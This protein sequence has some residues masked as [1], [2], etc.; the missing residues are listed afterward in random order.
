VTN[1]PTF[2]YH[3]DPLAT[4]SIAPSG[5]VCRSCGQPRGYIYTGPVYAVEELTDELCPWCIA[6]GSAAARFDARF[7]DPAGI[8]DYGSWDPV[9]ADTVEAV[10]RRTPG[11]NGWQQE[12]WWTHCGDA[13]AFLGSAGHQELIGQW[14]EAIPTIRAHLRFSDAQWRQYFEALDRTAGPTAYVFQCLH[15]GLLGGYSDHH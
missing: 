10:S 12:S 3:P 2:R 9:S 13:A 5:A 7:V 8:G 15:C 4:G 11:F 14:A 1:L 6:D